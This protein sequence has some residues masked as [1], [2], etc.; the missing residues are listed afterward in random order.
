MS[1]TLIRFH[2]CGRLDIMK[3]VCW[4]TRIF[5]C[6]YFVVELTVVKTICRESLTRSHCVF[7]SMISVFVRL[8]CIDVHTISVSHVK[9]LLLKWTKIACLHSVFEFY[10]VRWVFMRWVRDWLRFLHWIVLA[11]DVCVNVFISS[12]HVVQLEERFCIT[13]TSDFVLQTCCS[14]LENSYRN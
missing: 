5:S 11:W 10:Y 3:T 4:W 8:D 2:F 6:N 12:E 13:W 14:G 7:V 1:F 9:W